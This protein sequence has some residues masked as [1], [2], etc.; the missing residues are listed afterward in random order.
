MEDE[1]TRFD[2]LFTFGLFVHVVGSHGDLEVGGSGKGSKLGPQSQAGDS[3]LFIE[4]VSCRDNDIGLFSS[5]AHSQQG[6]TAE[7]V[8]VGIALPQTD[9]P[10]QGVGSGLCTSHDTL[11]ISAAAQ[12]VSGDPR[13]DECLATGRG[14]RRSLV[15]LRWGW[16]S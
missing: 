4:A 14:F 5:I 13:L 7:M 12:G 6:A 15:R 10:R 3:L 16:F 8:N 11:A 1:G 2:P 9:L